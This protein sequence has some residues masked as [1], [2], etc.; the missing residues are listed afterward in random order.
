MNELDE[1]EPIV[2]L[3]TA[4]VEEVF[5]CSRPTAY[6]LMDGRSRKVQ[7][8]SRVN[9][10]I[11]ISEVR[12][13]VDEREVALKALLEEQVYEPRKRLERFTPYVRS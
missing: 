7:S 5:S 2:E 4:E 6:N 1:I 13:I 10:V 12:A 11:P 8:G 9:R 3:N